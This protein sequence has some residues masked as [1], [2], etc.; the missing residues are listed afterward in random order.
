MMTLKEK[1]LGEPAYEYLRNWLKKGHVIAKAIVDSVDLSGGQVTALL[2]EGVTLKEAYEFA[3]GGKMPEPPRSA[4]RYGPNSVI[5]PVANTAKEFAKGI[6]T[7]I[8][9]SRWHVCIV[10]DLMSSRTDGWIK[11]T[12]S[13]VLFCGDQV[14]H[15]LSQFGGS[16]TAYDMAR[17][18]LGHPPHVGILARTPENSV[19]LQASREV[20]ESEL[21]EIAKNV[22]CLFMSAYDG[23]SY[24]IWRK[25]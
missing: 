18:A 8:G 2:P 3:K 5:K 21:R 10:E 9:S 25:G 14:F 12:N 19:I 22:M 17:E 6:D 15:W 7:F 11:K 24:V 20:P 13:K 16:G 1:K 23:E 4:W